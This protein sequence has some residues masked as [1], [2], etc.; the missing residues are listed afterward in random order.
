ME[1]VRVASTAD[2]KPGSVIQVEIDEEPIALAQTDDGEYLAT[3]DVCSH[4][5]V[6]LHDGFLEGPE[7]ECPQHG[8]KFDM[9]T[10]QVINL[11]ATQ[12]IDVYEV[13]SEGGDIYLRGPHPGA[14]EQ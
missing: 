12:P 14:K 6:L 10:G 1:W 7:I 3:T 4:E 13:K 5:Y 9:R 11:P 8:S 2:L